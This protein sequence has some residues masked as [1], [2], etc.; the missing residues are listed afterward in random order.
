MTN[1]EDPTLEIEEEEEGIKVV[2][3]EEVEIEERITEEVIEEQEIRLL[4]ALLKKGPALPT[5]LAVRTYSF[6]DE[7]AE[8]L[9]NLEQKGLVERQAIKTGEMIV[10]TERGHEQVLGG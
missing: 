3:E 5:E 8:P 10:L 9:A 1:N 4:Q 7:I 6:S 2:V